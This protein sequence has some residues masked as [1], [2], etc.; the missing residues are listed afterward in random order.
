MADLPEKR[1]IR[2]LAAPAVLPAGVWDVRLW[3][4]DLLPVPWVEPFW[5][6]AFHP[7]RSGGSGRRNNTGQG[8]REE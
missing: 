6:K 7:S 2:G 8:C 5:G 4:R 1:E 3:L